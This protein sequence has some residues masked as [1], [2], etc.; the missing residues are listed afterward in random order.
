M[1]DIQRILLGLPRFGGAVTEMR[2]DALCG[3]GDDS[4]SAS[5]GTVAAIPAA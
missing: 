2:K 4:T 1:A 3:K 5:V